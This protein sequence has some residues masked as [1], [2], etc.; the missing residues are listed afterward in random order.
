[1]TI[2]VNFEKGHGVE[3]CSLNNLF[4]LASERLEAADW[5]TY[6][7]DR[8]GILTISTMT[9]DEYADDALYD[10]EMEFKV[11]E[12]KDTHWIDCNDDS[13]FYWEIRKNETA[14]GFVRE[15][16]HAD[17]EDEVREIVNNYVLNCDYTPE[18]SPWKWLFELI[19]NIDSDEFAN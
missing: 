4:K 12:C 3:K 11:H 17:S 14:G 15:S 10:N 13:C 1:M 19:D 16:G 7:I 2:R 6:E 9:L 5:Y 18:S 8:D